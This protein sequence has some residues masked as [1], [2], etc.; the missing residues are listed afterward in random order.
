MICLHFCKLLTKFKLV[1]GHLSNVA[2]VWS[3]LWSYLSHRSNVARKNKPHI[4]ER[5][6]P[7]AS[8]MYIWQN[9]IS[10]RLF[11][12]HDRPLIRLLD[13]Q[14][15]VVVRLL[16]QLDWLFS[17]LLYRVAVLAELLYQRCQLNLYVFAVY[18]CC[19]NENGRRRRRKRLRKM[20]D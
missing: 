6:V 19:L 13:H 2:A 14:G 11:C 10:R 16:V 4:T 15:L 9:A 20:R 18:V 17:C 5:W 8:G 7:I 1:V 12:H 3:Y